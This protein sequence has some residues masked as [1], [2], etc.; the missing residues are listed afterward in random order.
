MLQLELP[1]QRLAVV[2]KQVKELS[3]KASVAANRINKTAQ[4]CV[5]RVAE[6]LRATDAIADQLEEV[7]AIVR[8]TDE[9]IGRIRIETSSSSLEAERIARAFDVSDSAIHSTGLG[10]KSFQIHSYAVN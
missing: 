9:T 6:S 2:A 4:E 5:V 1:G 7:K 10:T 8:S 3:V